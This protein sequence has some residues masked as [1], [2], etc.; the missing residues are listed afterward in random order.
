MGR[1]SQYLKQP[2]PRFDRPWLLILVSTLIIIFIL[3][4]FEPFNFRLGSVWAFMALLIYASTLLLGMWVSFVLFP[5]IFRT[6]Y[7]KENWT[8]GKNLLHYSSFLILF[9][10]LV[11]ITDLIVIPS[12]IKGAFSLSLLDNGWTIPVL[13]NVFATITMALIPIVIMTLIT[14]NKALKQNLQEAVLLNTTLSARIKPATPDEKQ[15]TLT[16]TTKDTQTVIPDSISYIEASGN[17]VDIYIIQDH[18]VYR[19][20]LRATIKQIE[21]Q[22]IGYPMLTRCHRAFIVN[23]NQIDNIRGNTH[24]YKIKLHHVATE[25]P[26]SRTY[27]DQ[28]KNAIA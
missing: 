11:T 15:I 22:L 2:Y 10:L 17:Y 16:G 19:K 14:Q 12:L 1:L 25:I 24:G 3:A 9:C 28:L 4:I 7:Q 5:R 8:I 13:V 26:V 27:I 20:Q 21:E 23:I 6:F 18:I